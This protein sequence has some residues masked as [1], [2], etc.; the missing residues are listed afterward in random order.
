M[1]MSMKR[2]SVLVSLIFSL[3]LWSAAPVMA[4]EVGHSSE[5]GHTVVFYFWIASIIVSVVCLL[6]WFRARQRFTA[7]LQWL[8]ALSL[9]IVLSGGLMY[10]YEKVD[11]YAEAQQVESLQH[12]HGLGF[13]IDGGRLF[14]P[15]H[16]G[17]A[18]YEDG[19]WQQGLGE[20]HDY[21]GYVQVEDGFYSS[22]HPAEGSRLKN[23]LGLVSSQ[24]EGHTLNK[25]ALYGEVDFHL[26]GAG[27]YSHAI[28]VYSP[29]ATSQ[30]EEPGL[31]YTINEGD[32]WKRIEMPGGAEN[33]PTAIAVHPRDGGTMAMG[34][35]KGVFWTEDYGES[36][37]K[38]LAMPATALH[39]GM[40]ELL[41]AAVYPGT[42][43]LFSFDLQ[44]QDAKE[45]ELPPLTDDPIMYIAQHPRQPDLLAIS[46]YLKNIFLSDQ[47]G[48]WKQLAVQGETKK[49]AVL[50]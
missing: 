39:F 46:T 34:N 3:L 49:K 42:A 18:V 27:Y 1:R 15:A 23:P 13:S 45:I 31:Y 2:L 6:L 43:E 17:L 22:G 9:L 28:Y 12:I 41:Y 40:D 32:T 37:T 36:F 47:D 20:R 25:L 14:V 21:M 16:H 24:D 5:L 50:P 30:M 38:L 11:S 10:G 33:L 7:K 29:N 48:G 35:S 8:L 44:Q 4:H 26:M 19:Q